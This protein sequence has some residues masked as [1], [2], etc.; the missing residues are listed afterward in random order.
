MK[1]IGFDI[2]GVIDVYPHFFS[3]VSKSLVEGGNEVHIITGAPKSKEVVDKLSELDI[4]Y[5]HF[6]SIV[7]WAESIGVP[8]EWTDEGP[9]MDEFL[10]DIAKARYCVQEAID[11]HI[12]DTPRYGDFFKEIDTRFFL[13]EDC[14]NICM[15]TRQVIA[16]VSECENYPCK[17]NCPQYVLFKD[18]VEN[19]IRNSQLYL[20]AFAYS[21]QHLHIGDDN[22]KMDVDRMVSKLTE[23]IFDNLV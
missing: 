11:L 1:K 5:T 10:W 9:K 3:E 8:V 2:H 19:T 17:K 15:K 7:D 16:S 22:A 18:S 6:F 12:D 21:V 4:T 14:I 23:A 20:D 13:F